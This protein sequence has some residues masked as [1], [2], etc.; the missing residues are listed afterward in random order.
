VINF[1]NCFFSFVWNISSAVLCH[2]SLIV[3]VMIK[4]S[5]IMCSS[6]SDVEVWHLHF[7]HVQTVFTKAN[8][9]ILTTSGIDCEGPY[10]TSKCVKSHDLC[11]QIKVH[12]HFFKGQYFDAFLLK[13][14]ISICYQYIFLIVLVP[15]SISAQ[16]LN[17]NLQHQN[18]EPSSFALF[19][20]KM[21]IL[22]I[23]FQIQHIRP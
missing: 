8:Y 20:N 17:L 6:I 12:F 16:S 3:G 22:N 5:Q 4:A 7:F 15:A 9:V 14:D 23:L 18:S 13:N 11:D 19:L 2:G 21:Y 1:E 10:I